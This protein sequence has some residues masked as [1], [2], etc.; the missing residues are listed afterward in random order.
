MVLAE[1]LAALLGLVFALAA[2]LLTTVTGNPVW[3]GIGSVAI[4][5][6]LIAMAAIAGVEVTSLLMNEAP[7][8]GL[9]GAIRAAVDE[10][11]A[12]EKVLNLVPVIIGSDRLMVAVQ[13]KFRE[14]P[15]G[16]ALV[17]AINS[18]GAGAPP[19]LPP[20]PAPL[21]GAGRG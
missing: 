19:A 8:L 7:L 11:P 17:E 14:Q 15:R 10:G 1:D 18:S 12:V 4:G 16:T 3:D 5:L 2:I 20:D 9:R 13:V 21:R 6:L